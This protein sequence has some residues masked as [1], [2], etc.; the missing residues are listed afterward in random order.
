MNAARKGQIVKKM[1]NICLKRMTVKSD[2]YNAW[3]LFTLYFLIEI[4]SLKFIFAFLL[5]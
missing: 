5:T 4:K 3:V 2:I 1:R